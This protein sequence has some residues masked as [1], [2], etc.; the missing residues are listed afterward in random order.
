[1]ARKITDDDRRCQAAVSS[2]AGKAA[3][4]APAL[5]FC[6]IVGPD[7]QSGPCCAG[8]GLIW[9]ML[10]RRYSMLT[11]WGRRSSFNLQKVMWLV[12]EL[13]DRAPAHRSG[14]QIRRPGYAGVS[15]DESAWPSSRS[16]TTTAPW[17]GNRTRSCATWLRATAARSFWS[18]DPAERSLADRWMDWSETTLQPDFLN[19]VFWGFYR[20]PEA[21]RDMRAVNRRIEAVRAPFPLARPASGRPRLHARRHADARGHPDRDQSLSATSTSRSSVHPCRTWK[22]G[23]RACRSARPI[24]STSWCR[25]RSCS[26]ASTIDGD[27]L[28]RL[29]HER[30]LLAQ[31]RREHQRGDDDERAERGEHLQRQRKTARSRAA[32]AISADGDDPP[33]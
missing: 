29:R 1:M 9:R 18:D 17:S 7:R 14:R 26:A 15:G 25:S 8:S 19:G 2:A 23:T 20:T 33:R 6:R 11:V 3:N 27:L 30:L 13:Q 31:V 10:A 4:I 22:P 32:T 28:R 5:P 12:G 21:Q 24:A 16:S